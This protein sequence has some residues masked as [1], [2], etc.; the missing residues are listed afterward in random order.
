MFALEPEAASMFCK[1]LRMNDFEGEKYPGDLYMPPE[2]VYAIVDAGGMV[3]QHL[4]KI[5][6]YC[7]LSY[8]NRYMY[9]AYC[10]GRQFS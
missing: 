4:L 9:M 7:Q 10:L 3:L 8:N 1:S 6:Y 5:N 2:T